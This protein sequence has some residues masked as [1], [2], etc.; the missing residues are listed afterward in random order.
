MDKVTIAA[1]IL[2]IAYFVA[3]EIR[4]ALNARKW[5]EYEKSED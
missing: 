2:G 1:I 5:R 4:A 3:V